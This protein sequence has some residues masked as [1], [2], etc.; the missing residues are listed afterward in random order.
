MRS[1]LL[2]KL[3]SRVKLD[4]PLAKHTT[5]H[6][7]G[8][9]DAFVEVENPDELR[10]VLDLARRGEAKL[11]LIGGGSNLLVRDAGVRGIVVKLTGQFRSLSYVTQPPSAGVSSVD[12]AHPSSGAAVSSSAQARAPMSHEAI[13]AGA[14]AVLSDLSDE[15]IRRGF[16][17]FCWAGGIPGTLG[18][19][20]LGNAGAWGHDIGEFV[21]GVSVMTRSGEVKDIRPVFDY[22]RTTMPEPGLII[23]GATLRLAIIDAPIADAK[24]LC[25]DY[26]E[27]KRRTQPL[28]HPSAGSVFKNPAPDKPAALLIDRAGLKGLRVEGACVSPKH[29]NFIVN[30]RHA[31]A[32][33]VVQLI[34]QVRAAVKA[35][36]GVDLDLEIQV[37]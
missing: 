9:A 1:E 21:V 36:S 26:I 24:L 37:W 10:F 17:N 34:E 6:L 4:E 3:G 20:I 7:G 8:P 16:N 29:A 25:R 23:L 27:R 33:D 5:F 31:S 22:R 15:S 2:K 32:T 35:Q 11:Y 30:D 13:Y 14:G 12:V 28:D 18:G 19:A